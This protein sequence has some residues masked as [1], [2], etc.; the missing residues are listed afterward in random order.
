LCALGTT[1]EAITVSLNGSVEHYLTRRDAK[2]GS[3]F[4]LLTGGALI[5]RDDPQ[6]SCLPPGPGRGHWERH[7]GLECVRCAPY[8]QRVTDFLNTECAF[9]C[10]ANSGSRRT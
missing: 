6:S 1:R 4:R 3:V 2:N 9:R 7:M 8:E 5:R 10:I